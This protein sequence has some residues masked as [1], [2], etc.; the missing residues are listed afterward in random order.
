MIPVPYIIKIFLLYDTLQYVEVIVG[1]IVEAD[2]EL[3]C[4]IGQ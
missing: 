3:F 4:Q 1:G 2:R